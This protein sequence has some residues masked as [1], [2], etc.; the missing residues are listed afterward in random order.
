MCCD[1]VETA[2]ILC[3]AANSLKLHDCR[4]SYATNTT[5]ELILNKLVNEDALIKTDGDSWSF[6]VSVEWNGPHHQ[7]TIDSRTNQ[8]ILGGEQAKQAAE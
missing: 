1:E 3:I 2:I 7:E 5:Q 8:I 4:M 6:L